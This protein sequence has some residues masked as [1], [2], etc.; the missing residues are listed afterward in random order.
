ME[1]EVLFD[2]ALSG[3][4]ALLTSE[5]PRPAKY[6][7]GL[8]RLRE[9]LA[10][11]VAELRAAQEARSIVEKRFLDGHGALFPDAA[12]AWDEQI[13]SSEAIADAVVRLVE[14][15]GLPAASASDSEAMPRR[16]TELV[17]DLVEPAKSAAPDKLGEGQ[18]ALG[19]A[20]DWLRTELAPRAAD[21]A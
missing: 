8:A 1:R 7:E 17:A 3:H 20:N 21:L 19:I 2:T 9:L 6:A 4:V 5:K 12:Q 13:R 14:L 15:D 16:T 11:R 10:F 18:R